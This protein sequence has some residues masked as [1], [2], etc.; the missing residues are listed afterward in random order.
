[1]QDKDFDLCHALSRLCVNYI[2]SPPALADKSIVA[3]RSMTGR[4][5]TIEVMLD[6]SC[7]NDVSISR[8][9]YHL[10]TQSLTTLSTNFFV[11]ALTVRLPIDYGYLSRHIDSLVRPIIHLKFF[12]WITLDH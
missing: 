11:N 7:A 1:M 9:V 6:Y 12:I 2:P 10:K 8:L 4:R 5:A 3:L